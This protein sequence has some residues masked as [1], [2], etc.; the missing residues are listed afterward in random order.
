MLPSASDLMG[1]VLAFAVPCIVLVTVMPRYISFLRAKGSVA[2]DVHKPGAP[3][4]ATPAGPMLVLALVLGEAAVYLVHESTIPV[5]VVEVAVFAGAIGLYDDLKGLGGIVKPALMALVAVPLIVEQQ[6]NQSLYTAQLYFP[7]FGSTGTHFIIFA[8]LIIAAMPVASN[9]FNMLDSFNG[10][11]SGFTLIASASL[12]I[13]IVMRG[14]VT[15]GFNWDRLAATLPLA[16]V[17]LCFYFYNRYPARIFDGDSGSLMFGATF[18]TLAILG[19]V[20][21]AALVAV[22]PAVINSYYIILSVRGFVEHKKMGARPTY[23]GEDGKLHAS[24]QPGAPTTLVRM[25]LL[26]E[27][28]SEKELVNFILVLALFAG[29]LSV[30]TSAITWLR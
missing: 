5:V 30:L 14:Y 12:I 17:A 3:K 16:A 1:I 28:R 2:S 25:I 21:I 27:P 15:A 18:A 10:E 20:E 6:A 23:L 7:F 24:D 29:V 26:G 19:G 13:G 4:V 9:A 22:I 8:I 11:I